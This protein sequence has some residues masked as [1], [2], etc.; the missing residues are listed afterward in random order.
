MDTHHFFP[1]TCFTNLQ[2]T[3]V[4][5]Q[6][7]VV[8]SY[9]LTSTS[10]LILF[11]KLNGYYWTKLLPDYSR[12]LVE[13]MFLFLSWKIPPRTCRSA[14]RP[15]TAP[16]DR[17]CVGIRHWVST[18]LEPTRKPTWTTQTYSTEIREFTVF[19]ANPNHDLFQCA[20]RT[21]YS[22][23][24]PAHLSAIDHVCAYTHAGNGYAS[25]PFGFSLH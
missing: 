1:H 16:A 13:E 24:V 20:V 18:Y 11:K 22:C 4:K 3:A 9:L 21:D 5:S 23:R 15:Q 2:I 10:L 12:I 17:D 14:P 19:S 6:L 25:R 7:D 8:K